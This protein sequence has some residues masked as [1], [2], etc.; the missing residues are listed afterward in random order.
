MLPNGLQSAFRIEKELIPV[1]HFPVSEVLFSK[2]DRDR[3]RNE[4]DKALELGNGEHIKVRIFF[5]DVEDLKL[6]ETTIWGVTEKAVLLKGDLQLPIHRIIEI[7]TIR[8]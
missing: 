7:Q 8:I 3:R 2:Y 1:L 6:V 4:L 5:E